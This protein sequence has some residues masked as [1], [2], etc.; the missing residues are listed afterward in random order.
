MFECTLNSCQNTA[1]CD[2]PTFQVKSN[3]TK[4]QWICYQL[5]DQVRRQITWMIN[6]HQLTQSFLDNLASRFLHTPSLLGVRTALGKIKKKAKFVILGLP[7]SALPCKVNH[8][9]TNPFK[10]QT[11]YSHGFKCKKYKRVYNEKSLFQL[12]S[13]S[14]KVPNLEAVDIDR[15]FYVPFQKYVKAIQMNI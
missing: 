1:I 4:S 15:I 2:I 10:K 8:K 14:T 3:K 5:P 9:L 12:P 7:S 11:I 6:Q 13:S